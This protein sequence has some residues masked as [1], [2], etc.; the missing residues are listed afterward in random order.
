MFNFLGCLFVLV[1]GIIFISVAFLGQ[2]IN[3]IL[4]LLG[5]K[6]RVNYNRGGFGTFHDF[7]SQQ[8]G[9]QQSSTR[10]QQYDDGPSGSQAGGSSPNGKIF[11]MDESEYVDFEEV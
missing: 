9:S 2:I 10:R 6:K 7:G 1:F 5:L 3:V 11:Q 4:S 8:S